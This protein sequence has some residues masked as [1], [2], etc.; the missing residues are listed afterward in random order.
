[1]CLSEKGVDW[2]SRYVDLFRF[3]QVRLEDL[4]IGPNGVV[5]T[6]VHNGLAI[7]ESSNINE[8][9]DEA[10]D[11]TSLMPNLPVDRARAREF[12]RMCDDFRHSRFQRW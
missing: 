10:F 11:G 6:P 5:P 4:A 1:M 8:Y 7:R 12:I 9:I 2:T 3:E